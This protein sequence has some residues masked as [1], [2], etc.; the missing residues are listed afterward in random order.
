MD[1]DSHGCKRER[2][3]GGCIQ[4][5]GKYIDYFYLPL[6]QVEKVN[7]LDRKSITLYGDFLFTVEQSEDENPVV[8]KYMM[9]L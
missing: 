1:N 7:D 4:Q 3:F 6:P 5:D 9:N 8:V 2:G